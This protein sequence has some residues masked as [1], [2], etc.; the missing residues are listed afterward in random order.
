M[1]FLDS[2]REARQS[3]AAAYQQFVLKYPKTV[4]DIH[5]FFEGRDDPSFYLSFLL[6]VVSDISKIHIYRCNNKQG[7]YET[8]KKA[9]RLTKKPSH[10]LFFVDKDHSDLM[11]EVYETA[12]NIY[13]TDFY[14]IEN[15]VVSE[16]MFRRVWE[17]FFN[18]INL[19][20]DYE[21]I[22]SKFREEL[23]RF[24]K[25]ALPL[26]AWI[27]FNKRKGL[28]P[29]LNN[30][31]LSE[32]YTFGQDLTLQ[33]ASTLKIINHLDRVCGIDCPNEPPFEFL[34][35]MNELETIEPKRYIRGKYELWFFVKFIEKLI[36][37]LNAETNNKNPAVKIRTQISESN[38][39]EILGPRV[40]LPQS[41]RNFFR[42][43]GLSPV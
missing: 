3:P 8:Y 39:I 20:I 26:S 12:V 2:L 19:T 6:Q 30:V 5:A 13:V 42:E 36:L 40:Q 34:L 32:L 1:S 14:S 22:V 10:V 25:F 18:I 7:V 28:K 4:E 31:K 41:L 27:L 24:Y 29:N 21:V 15:Y 33:T 37:A 23:Q 35:L 11:G 16:A 17:D 9:M 43:N 38:A